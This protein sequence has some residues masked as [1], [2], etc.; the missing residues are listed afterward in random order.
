MVHL[1]RVFILGVLTL[2]AARVDLVEG[3]GRDHHLRND[4]PYHQ[5]DEHRIL[6]DGNDFVSKCGTRNTTLQ[7][8]LRIQQDVK[9]WRQA[10]G[11]TRDSCPALEN[12]PETTISTYW[13]SIQTSSGT[14]GITTQMIT[15]SMS[16][17]NAAFAS[18]GFS[19]SLVSTT[20]TNNDGYY[21]HT[22]GSS[23]ETAMK[24]ALRQGGANTLN[25]YSTELSSLLGYAYLPSDY[26]EVGIL[27]GVVFRIQ[28]APG[29]T[30]TDFNEGDTLVHEVGHWM[31]LLHVFDGESCCGVGDLVDDTPCQS[32]ATDGCPTGKDTC[33]GAGVDSIDNFMDYSHDSCMT[34]FTDGQRTRM[35]EQWNTYRANGRRFAP[36]SGRPNYLGYAET[37]VSEY[38]K[39]ILSI[40]K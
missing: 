27:D 34:T 7:E 3:H 2:L 22:A 35:T 15:D 21:S 17:L 14:G 1:F 32:S 20:T 5:H 18:S 37:L 8:K 33:C 13:H 11:C 23:E 19:F 31:G 28:S 29:G 24:T 25:I 9:E 39:S 36:A 12:F 26:A 6:K 10:S 40:F 38:G 16:V 4:E 30:T